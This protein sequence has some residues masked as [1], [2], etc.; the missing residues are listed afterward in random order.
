MEENLLQKIKAY[1]ETL[2][3]DHDKRNVDFW[4][5]EIRTAIVKSELI[6][7]AGIKELIAKLKEKI[8]ICDATLIKTRDLTEKE[9]DKIFVQKDSWNWLVSFFEEPVKSL[10]RSEKRI[11]K[12]LGQ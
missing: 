8:A 3:W 1:R 7:F 5:K 2:T 6:N 10:E 12:T 9:R 11:K 4:E